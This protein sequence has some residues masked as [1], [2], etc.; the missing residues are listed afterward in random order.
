MISDAV[1]RLAL[2]TLNTDKVENG[3]FAPKRDKIFPIQ[4]CFGIVFL[5]TSQS[6]LPRIKL[7]TKR[8]LGPR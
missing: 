8:C 1:K 4:C 7:K 3:V 2:S 6:I 5:I